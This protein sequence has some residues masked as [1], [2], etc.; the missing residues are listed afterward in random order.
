MIRLEAV[1]RN[2][3]IAL[4]VFGTAWVAAE[5]TGLPERAVL[6]ALV[7]PPLLSPSEVLGEWDLKGNRTGIY[8]T[9]RIVQDSAQTLA[10]QDCNISTGVGNG[11]GKPLLQ[12]A[13]RVFIEPWRPRL[14]EILK[15]GR[16]KTSQL[17]G[18]EVEY[19]TPTPNERSLRCG[20][21]MRPCAN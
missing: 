17:D 4:S 18:N 11:W 16:L 7:M 1:I 9:V 13:P 20:G 6:P 19:L 14:Y 5:P 21:L 2:V 3:A 10:V 8:C 15:N 12:R